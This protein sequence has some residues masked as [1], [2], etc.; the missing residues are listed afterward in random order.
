M[1]TVITVYKERRGYV[2]TVSGGKSNG[3][4]YALETH[5]PEIA[6]NAALESWE[7]HRDNPDGIFVSV[8]AEV[9]AIIATRGPI[10]WERSNEPLP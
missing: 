2:M 10:P 8:P 1:R 3:Q 9:E 7:E 4:P 5:D 6:A